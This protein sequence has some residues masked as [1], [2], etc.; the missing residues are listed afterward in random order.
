MGDGL[1]LTSLQGLHAGAN[2]QSGDF[3]L[4]ADGFLVEKGVKTAPVKNF[5]VA[6]NFFQLLKQVTAVSDEVKFGVG[7]DYGA[8]DVLLSGMAISGK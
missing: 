2:V 7:S 3:S 4:Q 1:Y 6:G 8:P 5:T